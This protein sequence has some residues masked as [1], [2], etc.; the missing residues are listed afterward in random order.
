M[1]VVAVEEVA[2][3]EVAAVWQRHRVAISSKKRRY[4]ALGH[5]GLALLVSSSKKSSG[6][7]TMRI[8]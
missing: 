3:E 1:G 7:S 5:F 8:A 2:V 6:G 4:S